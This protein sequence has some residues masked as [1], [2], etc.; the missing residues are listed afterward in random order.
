M[1]KDNLNDPRLDQF[2]KRNAPEAPEPAQDEEM[3]IWKAIDA[4]V[5]NG[6]SASH[7]LP[8]WIWGGLIAAA[9]LGLVVFFAVGEK[10]RVHNQMSEGRKWEAFFE[11][12]YGELYEDRSAN[13]D[14]LDESQDWILL[15]QQVHTTG[16]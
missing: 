2:L 16:R 15:A 1:T 14:A 9:C 8:P 13:G 11:E 6:P 4:S 3:R 7:I 12:T 10:S 5:S